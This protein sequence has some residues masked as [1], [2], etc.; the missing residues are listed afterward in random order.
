MASSASLGSLD[1]ASHA[2]SS[3]TVARSPAAAIRAR[4]ACWVSARGGFENFFDEL[5]DHGADGPPEPEWLAALGERYGLEFDFESI[6]GLCDR[7]G[8]QF[9]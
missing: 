3:A 5:V 6:P 4:V 1:R 8:V 2:S 9:G 7:F